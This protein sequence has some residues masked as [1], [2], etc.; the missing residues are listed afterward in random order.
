MFCSLV[1][2]TET[3][4]HA[5]LSTAEEDIFLID[6]YIH[7]NGHLTIGLWIKSSALLAVL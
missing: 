6:V 5:C 4:M 1:L 3:T 7:F 2:F